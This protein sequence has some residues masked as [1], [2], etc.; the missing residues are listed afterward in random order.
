MDNENGKKIEPL[1]YSTRLNIK[2]DLIIQSEK[3]KDKY[4]FTLTG[5]LGGFTH[6]KFREEIK[7]ILD[8]LDR[9]VVI[10]LS[11][12]TYISSNGIES[13]LWATMKINEKG[14]SLELINP[15]DRLYNFLKTLKADKYLKIYKL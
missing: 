13:L 9:K 11:N 12:L 8:T 15:G 5:N 2:D 6:K 4:V 7:K 3:L 1:I 14:F 10:N